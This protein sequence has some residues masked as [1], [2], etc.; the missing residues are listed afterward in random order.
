MKTPKLLPCPFCG[1]KAIMEQDYRSWTPTY[2]VTCDGEDEA[3]PGKALAAS[4]MADDDELT[5]EKV[6]A[7]WNRRA[8]VLQGNEGGAK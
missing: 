4:G 5:A 7:R 1:S 2:Y 3:C 6:A 8:P